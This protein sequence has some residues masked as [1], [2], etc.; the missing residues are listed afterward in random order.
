MAQLKDSIVSGNLR[1][2]DTTLTDTI[3]TTVIKAPTTAGGTTYGPGTSGQVLKSNGSSVYWDTSAVTGVKGNAESSYRTGNVNLTPAN[4]GAL[5]LTGGT[6]SSSTFGTQIT[7]ERTGGANMAAL[8]FKNTAGMLGYIAASEVNGDLFH[9]GADT[10]KK[11]NILD[12]N[13]SPAYKAITQRTMYF[14]LADGSVAAGWKRVLTVP[15]VG[16]SGMGINDI[17]LFVHR[18]YNSTSPESFSVHIVNNYEAT[19]PIYIL[20]ATQATRLFTQIRI[21]KSSD[22]K[23]LHVEIFY[24]STARNRLAIQYNIIYP[25]NLD[26]DSYNGIEYPTNDSDIGNVSDSPIALTTITIPSTIASADLKYVSSYWGMAG[27]DGRDDIWI[28]TTSQGIIP[29]QGGNAGSGH[30][31]IGTSAWY[32]A[33]AYIDRVYGTTTKAIQDESGNNIKSNYAASFSIDLDAN[34]IV[35]KNKNGESLST[36]SISDINTDTDEKV[37][38]SEDT[39]NKIYPIGIISAAAGGKYT[40][41]ADDSIYFAENTHALTISNI[42]ATN[43]S[44]DVTFTSFG[45]GTADVSRSVFFKDN[46]VNKIVVSDNFKYNPSTNVLTVGSISGS[47]AKWTTGRTI[48]IGSTGKTLDG[49]SDVSWSLSEIGAAPAVSGGYLPLSGGTITG[50]IEYVGPGNRKIIFNN[51]GFKYNAAST[52]AWAGGLTYYNNAG[53]TNYGGFGA[54]G[55]TNS[56]SYFYMGGTYDAPYLKLTYSSGNIEMKSGATFTFGKFDAAST[57]SA[58]HVFFRHSSSNQI[59]VDDDF[60]YN[61]STNVLTVGSI[62][63]SAAKLTTGRTIALGTGV[64]S[65]A[66]TFDGSANITIPVTGIKEAYLT[67][68]GKD[69]SGSYGPMDAALQPRLGAN[70]M[71]FLK[72]AG[73]T[74]ERT[75]DGGTTWTAS[76]TSDTAKTGLFTVPGYTTKVSTTSTAGTGTAAANNMLRVTVATSA[77]SLYTILNKFIIYISTNG[78]SGCYVKIRT[79]LESDR[80]A[81]NDTWKIWNKSSKT[82]VSTTDAS[83]TEANTRVDISGWSGFNVINVSSVT[84]YGNQSASQYGNVQF[85]FGC[86]SNSSTSAG[87]EIYSIQGYGGVGWTVPSKMAQTG[88]LYSYDASQNATFPATLTATTLYEGS[89]ALTDK[90]VKKAGDSM[91]G[92]LLITT[93]AFG[94]LTIERRNEATAASIYFKNGNGI[95]GAIGM[96]SGV[97]SGLYRWT[98]DTSSNYKILDTSN[99]SVSQTLTSGTAIG[100]ITINGTATTLYCETNTN[101]DTKVTQSLTETSD[102]RPLLLGKNNQTNPE[103]LETTVTDQSYVTKHVF[104][105]PSSGNLY[106]YSTSGDSPALIFRRGSMIDSTLD[107]KIYN[108]SGALMMDRTVAGDTE[109]WQ[110]KFKLDSSGIWYG[111]TK[112]SLEGHTHSSIETTV[113]DVASTSSTTSDTWYKSYGILFVQNPNT[114]QSNTIR[115]SHNLRFYHATNG[116]SEILGV[117]ELVVGNNTASDTAGNMEGRL[118]LYSAGSSYIKI[119]PSETSTSRI[120]TLPALTG[121]AAVFP[122]TPT[123]DRV[124]VTDGTAGGIKSSNY[125]IATSVPSN[126]LFTDEKVKATTLAASTADASYYPTLVTAAGTAGVSIFD[127]IK[128]THTKGTTSANGNQMLILGNSTASGTA[129]NEFGAIRLYSTGQY[130][131]TIKTNG[132]FSSNKTL[133]LPDE[134]GTIATREYIDALVGDINSILTALL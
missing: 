97:N 74:I 100:T 90:Y 58:R 131:A 13:N 49:S 78:C 68:G 10:S 115:K 1:V 17:K 28:R 121:T 18:A 39:T 2:T 123:S 80:S 45:S 96:T 110:N 134:A 75:T 107:W 66:T 6:V 79:R 59:V 14:G 122:N 72:A 120:L 43:I 52:T 117:G 51:G 84:T 88:H 4:I 128:I 54:Y 47:A 127:S 93:A 8:G 114:S 48:T 108:S 98:A 21:T 38:V 29:Y 99:T 132:S 12:S 26:S 25:A 3:Q 57:A 73:I 130:H 23:K 60:K 91:S 89:T 11:Y 85:I 102:F 40:C 67:W 77:A 119:I 7:V 62:S 42:N 44:G 83:A 109:T 37:Q 63:G 103:N 92:A 20:H 56:L 16:T 55:T 129:N 64:T 15:A 81:G 112:V 71:E 31:S 95:L 65:T 35:L 87:M 76:S 33:S 41:V 36:I 86:T 113:T 34:N 27:P 126:A 61:P 101:T 82:W 9:Y 53:T 124:V 116:T 50:D 46:S 125:T 22:G 70:R 30:S 118:V 19:P 32:F 111:G 69:F 5:A 104:V 106:L 24:N 105:Q 94:A 133:L